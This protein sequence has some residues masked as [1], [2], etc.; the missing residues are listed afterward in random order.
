MEKRRNKIIIFSALITFV[1]VGVVLY[2][3]ARYQ[4][5]VSGTGNIEVAKWSIKLTDEGAKEISETNKIKFVSKNNPNVADDK[6][7]PGSSA[8]AKFILDP[9]GSE[10]AIDYG[11]TIDLNAFKGIKVTKVTA[12]NDGGSTIELVEN[13]GVWESTSAPSIS[14]SDVE[15]GKKVTFEV[16]ITWENSDENNMADTQI[17][18][19]GANVELDVTVTAS[20][21][22]A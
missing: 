1:V 21:H 9:T 7:A 10:V 15:S 17:G 22:V 12:T 19:D 5:S 3:S 14:L 2:T 4:E 6:I 16:F 8:T 13:N 18:K 20:Q 11:I